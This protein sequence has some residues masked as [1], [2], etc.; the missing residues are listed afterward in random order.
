[1]IGDFYEGSDLKVKV[2]LRASGF[3]QSS[4]NYIIKL[5]NDDDELTFTQTDV[6]GDGNGNYFL[7]V[8][9][10][11]IH[12]GSLIVQPIAF[13][14]DDDFPDSIRRIAGVPVNLGPIRKVKKR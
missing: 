8:P 5:Y 12:S 9:Y 13:V 4:D 11:A 14:H 7:P 6:K 3:N 1:M 10:D 2:N